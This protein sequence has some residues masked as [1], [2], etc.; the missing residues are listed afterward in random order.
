MKFNPNP[1]LRVDSYKCSH[2]TMYPPGSEIVS[3]YIEARGCDLGWNETVALGVQ[4]FVKQYLSDPITAA[5]IDD[6]EARITAHGLPFNREGWEI[7]LNE[8]K[9]FMPLAIEALPEGTVVGLRNVLVQMRN[10]DT[11]L[12]WL[13]SYFETALLRAVW[14]P[15]TVSTQSREIKKTILGHLKATGCAPEAINF[16]L[17]DFG[18]RGVSSS[19]SA[20]IGGFAHIVNFMGSDTLEGTEYA[21]QFYGAEE[22][23]AFSVQATEHSTV[24]SWG[25]EREAEMYRH[26]I[27]SNPGKI[28]DMQIITSI[29]SDSYDIYN[30]CANIYGEEL[31]DDVVA[32]GQRGGRLVVRPDSG[33][34]TVVPVE[35]V[36]LLAGKFGSVENSAGY[37]VL[38]DF[39]RVLQG[40]GINQDSIDQ[41]LQNLAAEGFA[42]E[43]MVFGMGGALLQ[44]INRDTL[45]F[46]M[47]ASAIRINGEWQDVY[48]DPITSQTK[49]SKRGILKYVDGKTI[50]RAFD[51]TDMGDM[52]MVYY[53]GQNWITV[54]TTLDEIRERAA[55]R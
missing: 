6:A 30:A 54:T 34:P 40:D 48:K 4:G 3:S 9:G 8:Y 7:I 2:F 41:I 19:E 55:I 11:R 23:P 24:T 25:R 39:I 22:M 36:K 44:G 49:K 32:L 18:A 26:C 50:R 29:V 33:D 38:P 17:H 47:K 43:N 20:G 21:R 12:P 37:K 51:D 28:G 1:I 10:T 13:T 14:Y 15:T 31:Y 42:A 45:K 53:K 27:T 52:Q 16:M 35:C 46:A 5:D